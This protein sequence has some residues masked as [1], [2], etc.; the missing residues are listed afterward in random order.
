[1]VSGKCEAHWSLPSSSF[2]STLFTPSSVAATGCPV[3]FIGI[4]ERGDL[5]RFKMKPFVKKL[6]GKASVIYNL[7][8]DLDN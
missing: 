6:K 4:G 7:V 2:I 3:E 1:M 8:I 5:Q